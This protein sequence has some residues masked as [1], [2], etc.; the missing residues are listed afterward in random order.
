MSKR[1]ILHIGFHKTGTSAIQG[2]LFKNRENLKDRA[3]LYPRPLSKFPS[4]TELVST[5]FP[6]ELP[7]LQESFEIDDVYDH[8]RQ[9]IA[10]AADGTT[11]FLSS[12]EFCRADGRLDKIQYVYDRLANIDGTESIVLAYERDPIGFLVSLYHHN[13]RATG[14]R[15]NF[16][17]FL[18]KSINI[19]I[20]QFKRRVSGWAE[21]FGE[22][23][24]ILRDYDKVIRSFD[25]NGIVQDLFEFLEEP[26]PDFPGVH[27]RVN[28]GLHPWMNEAYRAVAG[29]DLANQ[30][31]DRLR[32]QILQFGERL[33]RVD[34]AE[35]Y[36]GKQKSENYRRVIMGK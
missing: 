2:F 17:S 32:H 15:D 23:S 7:W 1:L 29:L 20:A 35:H 10:A 8:Y 22:N 30:D 25:R 6:G 24:V 26:L 14:Y 21:V 13:V 9:L 16:E 5:L 19:K 12:E 31:A 3:I 4:H 18:E 11:V 27:D 33:P 36:L 28:I 34:A